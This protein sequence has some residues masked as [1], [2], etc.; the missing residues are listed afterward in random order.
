MNYSIVDFVGVIAGTAACAAL[1][2]LPGLALAH[3]TNVFGFRRLGTARI[4][5]LALVIGYA[6]LAGSGQHLV[7]LPWARRGAGVQPPVGVLWP[8]CRL[9]RR[10]ATAGSLCAFGMRRLD[11]SA[12]LCLD[13]LRHRRQA[14]SKFADARYRQ[15]RCNRAHAGRGWICASRRS[16]FHARRPCRILLFLLCPV[17]ARGA[18]LRRLDRLASRRGRSGFLDRLGNRRRCLAGVRKGRVQRPASPAPRLGLD[19]CGRPA[20]CSRHFGRNLKSPVARPNQLVERSGCGLAHLPI[21]G[22][23]SRG[24]SD[25]L[26]GWLSSAGGDCRPKRG[27]ANEARHSNRAR[28]RRL[29][30]SRGIVDLGHPGRSGC[31]APLG[32]HAGRRAPLERRACDSR[33]RASERGDRFALSRRVGPLSRLWVGTPGPDRA[34]VPVLRR[35]LCRRHR[36][37]SRPP[38]RAAGQ[39]PD[40]IWRILDWLVSLLASQ[41]V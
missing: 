27:P 17:G 5:V 26:L 18:A 6:V 33:C 10:S 38:R 3:I 16:V 4:Y 12:R 40:R 36:P 28:G 30:F 9:A 31:D 19:V 15:A 2:L 20:N 21:V 29:R 7:P 14:L 39:L 11:G 8:A 35:A 37:L 23:T 32:G 24:V 41:T 25:C 22:P 1:L 13:R 34:G